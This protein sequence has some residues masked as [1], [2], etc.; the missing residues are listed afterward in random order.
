MI[1]GFENMILPYG[2]STEYYIDITIIL[3]SFQLI[4]SV[5]N[6]L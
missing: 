6:I 1:I 5:R 2:S 4:I 3:I